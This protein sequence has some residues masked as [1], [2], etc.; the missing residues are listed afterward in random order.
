MPKKLK[1]PPIGLLRHR[2]DGLAGFHRRRLY[3][4]GHDALCAAH[5]G[6]AGQRRRAAQEESLRRRSG[7]VGSLLLLLEG[8]E[9]HL[10]GFR[11][12]CQ[13]LACAS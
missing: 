7:Q 12:S 2:L 8:R 3:R 6:S 11:V 1:S 4:I 10:G 5:R 13:V 9:P